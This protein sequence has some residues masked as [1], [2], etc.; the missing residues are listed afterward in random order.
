[1]LQAQKD[2]IIKIFHNDYFAKGIRPTDGKMK[3]IAKDLHVGD[4]VFFYE[5][6]ELAWTLWYRKIIEASLKTHDIPIETYQKIVDFYQN[7][8][9]SYNVS[10][11]TKKS[12]Q[13][14][15]TS[16]PIGYAAG[17]FCGLPYLK[18]GQQA[19]E[20]SAGNGLLV[21]A[22][23]YDKLVVNELDITRVGNLRHQKYFKAVTEL[24]A[25]KPFPQYNRSMDAVI[26]NPP[27]GKLEEVNYDFEGFRIRKLDHLMVAHALETM[28][29]E[30]RAALIIGD[31]T[32]FKRNGDIA[33]H[34][35]FF[36]WLGKHY[37]IEDMININ[38]QK[39]YNR[40][41]T[42]F[43][44]R[45]IL[46]SGRKKTPFGQAPTLPTH[47]FIQNRVNT[48]DELWYRVLVAMDKADEPKVTIEDLL[49]NELNKLKIEMNTK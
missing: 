25:S 11:S 29:D 43:P 22:G 28:K 20:P 21:I 19:F 42:A 34:R 12:F 26:T 44:L 16:A 27:F 39:L 36:N 24:D 45:M 48:F 30:G 1:M 6:A 32:H 7:V 4:L 33:N 49:G 5:V 8:Q 10:S 17:I 23:A 46:I 13:Q 9:P 3:K 38:S 18:E 15:S 41:G 40:Q 35:I 14:Y 47:P 2:K 31:W 37:Y